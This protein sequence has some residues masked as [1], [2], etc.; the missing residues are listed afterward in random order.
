MDGSQNCHACQPPCFDCLSPTECLSCVPSNYISDP[1]SP[2]YSCTCPPGN[3]V[4]TTP[5]LECLSCDTNCATCQN[6]STQC[7]TCK[8]TEPFLMADNTCSA[9]CPPPKV[10]V[11]TNQCLDCQSPCLTC[12]TTPST[13]L[14]CIPGYF[15][16]GTS[17]L[18]ICPSGKFGDS[19][20]QT[21]EA[22][23][24]KCSNCIGDKDTCTG[25][26]S[27]FREVSQGKCICK[28]GYIE[29]LGT[30]QCEVDASRVILSVKSTY[31]AKQTQ[32]ISV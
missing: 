4:T 12:Q 32:T 9:I 27:E 5:L 22:C 18:Q 11:N 16:E 26:T 14:T 30:Q 19:Q 1:T 20:T 21:C 7:L 13:C 31:W 15:K 17:C 23:N 25:C 10:V 29:N 28:T 6:L 3:F 24:I 8:V 2:S